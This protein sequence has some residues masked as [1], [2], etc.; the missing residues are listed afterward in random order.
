MSSVD[1]LCFDPMADVYDDT[2]VIN[3]RCF[4]S[5]LD[6]LTEKYPPSRYPN[7]LEPGTG[8]GRIG[9]PLAKRGYQVTGVD[10]SSK[11]L[12]VLANKL[13]R[14]KDS[15]PFVFQKADVTDLPFQNATFDI[16]IA[17]HLFHLIRNWQRA[18][19]EV[20]RVLKPGAPIICLT[21]GTGLEIPAI[22]DR[23]RAICA[24]YGHPAKPVGLPHL[25]ELKE[26]FKNLERQVEFI[27][28]RWQWTTTTR[29]D[30]EFHRIRLRY[31]GLTR[32]VPRAIHLKVVRKLKRELLK[33]YGTLDTEVTVPNQIRLLLING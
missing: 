9:I 31:Y 10:I 5:F 7:L 13:S 25:S 6:F 14:R 26:Y 17:V 21:T 20:F 24:E 2:R 8:T 29:V 19:S 30:E 27:E 16:T 4:N 22:N 12:N 23:Y 1:S 11:M 3:E 32:L 15:V 33:E 28:N 18:I